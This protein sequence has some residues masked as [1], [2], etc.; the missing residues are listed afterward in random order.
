[1]S[2]SV[3]SA[4]SS[5]L[6]SS[7]LSPSVFLFFFLSASS[8]SSEPSFST[9]SASL[10]SPGPVG[11]PS[12]SSWGGGTLP[13]FRPSI[14]DEGAQDEMRQL[15]G[16]AREETDQ[17]EGECDTCGSLTSSDAS[18]FPTPSSLSS[19]MCRSFCFSRTAM[20]P[21]CLEVAGSAPVK[22]D[23]RAKEAKGGSARV[24]RQGG[25]DREVSSRLTGRPRLGMGQ[26]IGRKSRRVNAGGGGV[27]G[28]RRGHG[29]EAM[30]GW[31]WDEVGRVDVG[32]V[33]ELASGRLMRSHALNASTRPCSPSDS[34]A[35]DQESQQ[36]QRNGTT[37]KALPDHHL[38]PILG[39][40]SARLILPCPAAADFIIH[41]LDRPV[42]SLP[43]TRLSPP[44]ARSSGSPPRRAFTAPSLPP[45]PSARPPLGHHNSI[46]LVRAASSPRI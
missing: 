29:S 12:L 26:V 15:S 5:V 20:N 45:R 13:C 43:R 19:G 10:F 39:P 7:S 11:N 32:W 27:G 42:S 6:P 14:F 28:S 8:L 44:R 46:R 4:F 33:G 9:S 3:L 34:K 16:H 1:M 35:H 17:V 38:A 40:A 23:S 21:S 2:P 30:C 22:I 41:R 31:G 18:D 36:A 24:R 37:T 25:Q